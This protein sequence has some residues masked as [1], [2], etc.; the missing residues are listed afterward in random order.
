MT[1]RVALN[2]KDVAAMAAYFILTPECV[3]AIIA[4]YE[5]RAL[6]ASPAGVAAPAPE[7]LQ[8][9]KGPCERCGQPTIMRTCTACEDAPKGE[10]TPEPDAWRW[11]DGSAWQFTP[12]RP[13]DAKQLY[14]ALYAAPVAPQPMTEAVAWYI[15]TRSGEKLNPLHGQP[16]A[17]AREHAAKEGQ[18]IVELAIKSNGDGNG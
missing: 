15:L 4:E 11:W 16:S 2:D 13:T 5:A 1:E 7:S 3:R 6:A 9:T 14:A 10:P 12:E 8:F 17:Y 18:T